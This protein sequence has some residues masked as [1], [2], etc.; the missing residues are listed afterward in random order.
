MGKKRRHPILEWMNSVVRDV[1]ICKSM[2]E[3]DK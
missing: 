3:R 2:S 1:G